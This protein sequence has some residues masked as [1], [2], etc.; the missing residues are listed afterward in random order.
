MFNEIIDISKLPT[1]D[2]HGEF[3]DIARIRI[4]EF[5]EVARFNGYIIEENKTGYEEYSY[6]KDIYYAVNRQNAYDIQFL[7]LEN[8]EYAKKFILSN[9]DEIKENI[10]SNSYVKSDSLTNYEFYHAENENRRCR[11]GFEGAPGRSQT[12]DRS[13]PGVGSERL[14]AA[15]PGCRD[16]LVSWCS[17]YVR[18]H[19]Y[20][21]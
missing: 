9:V 15:H 4:N 12:R 17:P 11:P 19:G 5:I 13:H 18:E 3:S 20:R 7:I 8:D 21:A 14:C 6:I 1:L 10:D 2:L 16:H